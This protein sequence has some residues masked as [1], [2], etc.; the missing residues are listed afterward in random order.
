MMGHLL[1][2]TILLCVIFERE[3]R[4]NRMLTVGGCGQLTDDSCPIWKHKCILLRSTYNINIMYK[5]ICVDMVKRLKIKTK[6]EFR[7]KLIFFFCY[8]KERHEHFV[9]QSTVLSLHVL[10]TYLVFRSIAKIIIVYKTG[11]SEI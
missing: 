9:P 7:Q 10:E 5:F 1:Q 11:P 6:F 8:K 3:L 2:E 4:Y